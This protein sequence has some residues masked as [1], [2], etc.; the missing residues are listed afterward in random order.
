MSSNELGLVKPDPRIYQALVE[1]LGVPASEVV[2]IDDT[3]A[4]L[5]AATALGMTTIEFK[6]VVQCRASLSWLGIG[7]L[8][9]APDGGNSSSHLH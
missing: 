1:R 2:Y 9:E 7:G 8:R 3:A 5:P 6:N 4:N